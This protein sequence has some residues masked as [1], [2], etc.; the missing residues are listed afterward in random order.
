MKKILFLLILIS[1]EYTAYSQNQGIISGKVTDKLNNKTLSG[2]NVRVIGT[3]FGAVTSKDGEFSIKNLSP[4]FYTLQ[5]SGIGY[6]PHTETN[7]SVNN[8][9]PTTLN[10]ELTEIV[11]QTKGVEVIADYFDRTIETSASS[12]SLNSQDVRRAPGVQEDIIRATQLLPGVGISSAGRND[13][14][15]RGGAPFE[16]LFVVDNFEVPN[17][18]HFGTQGSTGGPLALINIDFVE[19]VDFSS[20]AF[21]SYYGDKTSS[22]TNIRLRNGNQEKFGGQLNLS[23][24]GFGLNFEG[25][26]N[27]KGSYWFSARRSYLDFIF[28][29]AGFAFIP[30]YWDFQGKFNFNINSKNQI[31]FLA[32]T[33]LDYVTL[34]NETDDQLYSNSKVAA[35]N[36]KQYF[37]A[38]TW[39]H[40]F[41]KGYMNTTLGETL[42]LYE[43]TQ[44][45]S[46]GLPIFTNNSKEAETALKFDFFFQLTKS[47]D[48]SF[49]NQSKFASSLD[50]DIV[51]PGYLRYDTEG[52][53]YPFQIDTSFVNFKNGTYVNLT[54]K[55]G[56]FQY[57]AGLRYDYYNN[58]ENN[59]YIS[60]RFL[61]GYQIDGKSFASISGGTYYQSPSYIW[62]IGDKINSKLKPIRS[63]QIVLSYQ[64]TIRKDLK[65]QIELYQKWYKDYPA[66]LF[67]PWSVLSPSGFDDITSD[68][69][70]GIEPLVSTGIGYSRGMEVFL[71]K[72][73]SDIPLYGLMSFTFSDT[74]FKSLKGDYIQGAYNTPIVFNLSAGYLL[75]KTW[76][77]AAKF[78][79]SSGL[80]IT[81]F[82]TTTGKLILD[83]YNQGGRMPDFHALDIRLDKRWSFGHFSLD[84]YLDIQNV[85]GRKNVAGYK[86]DPREK[87]VI[88]QE[89]FGILP[90]IGINFEF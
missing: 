8:T 76:E 79:Y 12:Q 60:P 81:P 66:R 87:E 63:D 14:V 16:N 33:A 50:Y 61:I 4:G 56:S 24:T 70:Y 13:L 17:I 64:R 42:S 29:A 43:V 23:A 21:S 67:R 52:T 41:E 90:S 22:F 65:F 6:A 11:I 25:P 80:P 32:I 34:N 54:Q 51:I 36:Q 72:K 30:E 40:F 31:S 37:S 48:I 58:L 49:G 28:K 38:I 35:P 83:E 45:D 84:T 10:I 3:K 47:L 71:Q 89:S 62:T 78:R 7:I 9:K 1:F 2:I 59:S 26:V 19:N 57:S 75:G 74:K 88:K 39:K 77:I 18:N 5:I 73:F 69:P 20:G 68:I 46:L 82:D 55:I 85:Y 86:W 44:N 53:F 15:V 27:D